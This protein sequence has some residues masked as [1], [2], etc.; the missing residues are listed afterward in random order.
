MTYVPN[1]LTKPKQLQFVSARY[2]QLR[3]VSG[4]IPH[5]IYS[6]ITIIYEYIWHTAAFPYLKITISYDTQ[7]EKYRKSTLTYLRRVT[8]HN[9][10]INKKG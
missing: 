8:K 7:P 3:T 6:Q 1:P 4:T 2:D 10:P 5:F 9:D